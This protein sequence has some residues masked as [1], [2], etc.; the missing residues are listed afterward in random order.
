[1]LRLN[2]QNRFNRKG[3]MMETLKSA[4]KLTIKDSRKQQ[5]QELLEYY[6]IWKVSEKLERIMR[7]PRPLMIILQTSVH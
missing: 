5:R 3:H 7:M 1:M 2:L 6:I 4:H